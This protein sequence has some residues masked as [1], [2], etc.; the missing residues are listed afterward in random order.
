MSHFTV[1][2]I[3]A[4]PDQLDE[5]LE[6]FN[7]NTEVEPYRKYADSETLKW[8]A[9]VYADKNDGAEPPSYEELATWLNKHWGGEDDEDGR[10]LY[11]PQGGIYEM[12][13]YNPLSRWDWWQ[14]GGRWRGY[15]KVKQGSKVLVGDAGVFENSARYDADVVR[16]GDVDAEYMRNESGRIAGERWDKVNAAFGDTPPAESW[17]DVLAKHTNADGEI[18]S[19]AARTEY[20]GQPRVK[21]VKEA[22]E[23]KPWEEQLLGWDDNVEDYQVS[24]EEYVQAARDTALSPFAYIYKGEW[25][26]PGKMGWF[27]MST[28]T[29]ATRASYNRE[30]NKLWDTLPDDTPVVLIDAHI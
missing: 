13:T 2:V 17:E 29:V 22:D 4:E 23:G 16:K 9:K 28:D 30:F 6:P 1:M 24:R 19:P 25:Y 15:F 7:E 26:E 10:L 3:G 11:E 21:K 27:G 18:N 5:I 14:I 8:Y 12:S 20:G